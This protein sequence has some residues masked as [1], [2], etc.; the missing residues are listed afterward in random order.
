MPLQQVTRTTA[1]GA[2]ST[3]TADPKTATVD[4]GTPAYLRMLHGQHWMQAG[5]ENVG[6]WDLIDDLMHGTEAMRAK[7][8]DYLPMYEQEDALDYDKRLKATVLHHGFRQAVER[9]AVRPF[10][11]PVQIKLPDEVEALPE[12]LDRIADNVDGEGTDLTELARRLMTD[13]VARGLAIILVDHPT[14]SDTMNAAQADE[15]DLRPRFKRVMPR[16]LIGWT[17]TTN[18][19]GDR[20]VAEVR[21][22]E[23]RT[24]KVGE[25][26]QVDVPYIRCIKAPRVVPAVD[27][28]NSEPTVQELPGMYAL[29][30]YHDEKGK[31]E[32]IEEGPHSYPGLPIVIMQFGE[33]RGLVECLPPMLDVAHLNLAHWKS[34]SR[35][36]QYI[37]TIRLAVLFGSGMN[38]DELANGIVIGPGRLNGSTNPDAKLS[39]AEHSGA[40]AAAGYDEL[41]RLEAKMAEA[42]SEPMRTKSGNPTATGKAID[43]AKASTDVEAWVRLLESGLE[44]AYEVAA[45]WRGMEDALPDEW[46]IDI[47][48]EFALALSKLEDLAEIRQLR[49]QGDLTRTTTIAEYT[50]RGVIS[51]RIDPAEEAERVDD[52]AMAAA[53]QFGLDRDD[54]EDENEAPDDEQDDVPQDD[55]DDAEEA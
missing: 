35:Q 23:M 26:G 28:E 1:V 16:N 51:D 20:E 29:Y 37:D 18:A 27:P 46:Q 4:V 45:R 17:E 49:Q 2:V 6:G 39:Y 15:L 36:T 43:A 40:G 5:A 12:P 38:E 21:I 52:E 30:R 50:R 22:K 11:K 48:S 32:L 53:A 19:A 55:E 8:T 34:S 41:D 47:W 33:R 54:G 9:N 24:E 14:I 44:Q 10:A 3:G 7:R 42:G 25:F 13:G 31:Y